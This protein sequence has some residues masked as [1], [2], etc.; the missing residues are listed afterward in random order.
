MNSQERLIARYEKAERALIDTI[1]KQEARG[2]VTTYTNSLLRQIR[3]ELA[4]LRRVTPSLVSD[5]VADGY[6]LGLAGSTTNSG[7]DF[8]FLDKRQ[9]AILEDNITADLIKATNVVG[10]HMMD[11][12]R[13]AALEATAQKITT[14]QTIRDMKKNL[15]V[16]LTGDEEGKLGV[17]YKNGNVVSLSKY[18]AMVA[19][20]TTAEAATRA[21]LQR[22]EEWG[23]DLVKCTTHSP[24]C[25]ICAL[26]SGRVFASTK[27]AANGKYYGLRFP[28]L[29][30]TALSRGYYVIHPN[31][32]H[33]FNSISADAYSEAELAKMSQKS[34]Q[35][36]EDTRSDRERKLYAEGQTENRQRRADEIQFEQIRA[37][38]PDDA[39]AS[40]GA[41]RSAKRANSQ[42]FQD[43]VS[44]L[45]AIKRQVKEEDIEDIKVI[46]A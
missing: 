30:D 13:A 29:Y 39:Y 7:T 11:E 46:N 21:D 2:N 41:F 34:M 3:A 31:C 35:P 28:Y 45:R 33:A 8:T 32:E 10:R 17:R 1:V 22:G 43:L 25:N 37:L 27:E 20:T 19:R 6:R 14:G 23:H 9:I 40:F 15:L 16:T 12:L 24:T 44:D 18:T 36:F 38:L 42:R 26:Y 5:V 4:K